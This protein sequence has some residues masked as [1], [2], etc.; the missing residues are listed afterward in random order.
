MVNFTPSP[1]PSPE[2]IQAMCLEIQKGWTA[3]E[4]MKRLRQDWRP[5]Y[6]R[7]DGERVELSLDCYDAHH[8]QH[9]LTSAA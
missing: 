1:D 5:A 7:C 6:R 9:E 8:V 2:E 3:E 4:K